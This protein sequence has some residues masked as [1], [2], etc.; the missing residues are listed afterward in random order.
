MKKIIGLTG[1]S[2]VGKSTVA[3]L[4]LDYGA[5]VIDAD[6]VAR[7]VVEKGKP[8]LLEIKEAFGNEVFLPDGNLNRSQMAEIVFCDET[9]LHK[10]TQITHKY[11][12]ADIKEEAENAQSR[13]VV[14]DAPLLFESGLDSI[15]HSVVCVIAERKTR[16]AR[17]MARDGISREMAENRIRAQKEDAFYCERSDFEIQN[18][19][20]KK[21]LKDAVAEIIKGVPGE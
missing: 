20:D 16:I 3:K 15:C 19:G 11:I 13:L 18:N 9:A 6:I 14:I 17:I 8:A 21:K 4:F 2:G 7:K 12:I 10:L 5:H 1:G